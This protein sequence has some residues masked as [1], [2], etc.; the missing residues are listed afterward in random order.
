[1][2]RQDQDKALRRI[3]KETG[4]LAKSFDVPSVRVLALSIGP[5]VIIIDAQRKRLDALEPC[6][7]NEGGPHRWVMVGASMKCQYCPAVKA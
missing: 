4:E 3:V 5:L 2:N 7:Q 1:M 6:E